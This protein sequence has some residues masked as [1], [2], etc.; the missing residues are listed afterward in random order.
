MSDETNHPPARYHPEE[1]PPPAI[2][3]WFAQSIRDEPFCIPDA[4]L[5]IGRLE[6][7]RARLFASNKAIEDQFLS[8]S[9]SML[10]HVTASTTAHDDLFSC[11]FKFAGCHSA[12]D[13]KFDWKQHVLHE[14]IHH[15]QLCHG[16]PCTAHPRVK[17]TPPEQT[18]CQSLGSKSGKLPQILIGVGSKSPSQQN[19]QPD[20]DFICPGC[21]LSRSLGCPAPGCSARFHG[22]AAW[23]LRLDHIAIHLGEMHLLFGGAEDT[24]FVQWASHSSV[25]IIVSASGGNGWLLYTPQKRFGIPSDSGYGSSIQ[26][27]SAGMDDLASR[28]LPPKTSGNKPRQS[29][30]STVITGT[31]GP[32]DD[33]NDIKDMTTALYHLRF[34]STSLPSQESTASTDFYDVQHERSVSESAASHKSVGSDQ[35]V[36]TKN[37]F[38]FHMKTLF[39]DFGDI[40]DFVSKYSAWLFSQINEF[41]NAA[42]EAQNL[43]YAG[44]GGENYYGSVSGSGS[45]PNSDQANS[46]GTGLLLHIPGGG[47]RGNDN[48]D[49][50]S[51]NQNLNSSMQQPHH[52]DPRE[53]ACPFYKR[54]HENRQCSDCSKKRFLRFSRLL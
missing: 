23:S 46:N 44:P 39:G 6:R 37:S 35:S 3:R 31:E 41:S 43:L 20:E 42:D 29:D 19:D 47:N 52:S 36:I 28:L 38:R 4:S 40:D 25:K 8:S 22:I 34:E 11:I 24:E 33:S 51:P 30:A 13:N 1:P 18:Q 7:R 53:F 49:D 48:D 45:S 5:V 21:H 54:A 32:G 14:H 17:Q 9:S 12:Y 27:S 10:S 26:T 2:S 50:G 16:P 15:H